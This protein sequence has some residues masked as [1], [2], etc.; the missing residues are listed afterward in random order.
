MPFTFLCQIWVYAKKMRYE[1]IYRYTGQLGTCQMCIFFCLFMIYVCGVDNITMIFV[2][3]EMEHWCRVPELSRYSF[4]RQKYIA[5]PTEGS[6]AD[7]YSS[8]EMFDLNYTAF[9]DDDFRNW[10]R[11][12]MI[13]NQTDRKQCT[14]WV[15]DQTTFVSTIVSRV[16][17]KLQKNYCLSCVLWTCFEQI[18]KYIHLFY[19]NLLT[20]IGSRPINEQFIHSVNSRLH[21]GSGRGKHIS[22]GGGVNSMHFLMCFLYFGCFSGGGNLGFWGIPPG[23]SWK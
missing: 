15:Y 18:S 10:N 21:A 19:I 4:E 17:L 12:E 22:G 14:E 11:T 16:N 7:S 8:C 23:D 9:G 13:A 2:G 20:C 1:E 6:E 3:G 5:V